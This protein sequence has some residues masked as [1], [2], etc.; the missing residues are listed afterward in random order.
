MDFPHKQI[1]YDQAAHLG[2]DSKAEHQQKNS[3]REA[4]V[5]KKTITAYN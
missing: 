4:A 2:L 1:E 3:Q 5:T